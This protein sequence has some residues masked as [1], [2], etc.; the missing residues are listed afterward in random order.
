M[1][2]WK[3][4][5]RNKGFWLSA[6]P[7]ALLLIQA[8]LACFG[9]SWDYSQVSEELIGLANAVFAFLAIMGVVQDP[10]TEGMGDSVQALGYDVPKPTEGAAVGAQKEE[11]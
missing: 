1:I 5:V 11:E 9:I 8:V 7:A 4:R 6:I 3:V 2:N 10:T